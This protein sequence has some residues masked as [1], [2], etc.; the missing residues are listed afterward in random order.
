[1]FLEM[2]VV[3]KL[4]LMLLKLV[5]MQIILAM[6][7]RLQSPLKEV[8]MQARFRYKQINYQ[9]LVL[10]LLGLQ[11]EV[12]RLAMPVILMYKQNKLVSTVAAF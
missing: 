2:A 7:H 5:F 3:A 12:Q 9:L 10:V 1:M 8:V 11:H 6:P 4:T